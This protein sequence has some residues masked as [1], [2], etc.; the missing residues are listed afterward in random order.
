MPTGP[1]EHPQRTHRGLM[2]ESKSIHEG[3]AK[4]SQR[5]RR[6]LIVDLH[7]YCAVCVLWA[8][9][10]KQPESHDSD[11]ESLDSDVDSRCTRSL[12]ASPAATNGGDLLLRRPVQGETHHTLLSCSLPRHLACTPRCTQHALETISGSGPCPFLGEH[13][14]LILGSSSKS[15]FS[16]SQPSLLEAAV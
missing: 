6:G 3:L 2:K 4:D 13:A 8:S 11:V 5:T 1:S 14:D 16:D 12:E 7:R 10:L 9:L 15:K